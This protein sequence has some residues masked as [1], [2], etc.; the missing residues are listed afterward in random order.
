MPQKKKN[1]KK[2]CLLKIFPQKK[3]FYNM[4]RKKKKRKQCCL[5]KILK[6]L[7]QKQI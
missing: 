2:Y 6:F 4:P 3:I 5:L 1:R 7:P